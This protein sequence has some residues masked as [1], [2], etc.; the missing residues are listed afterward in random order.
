MSRLFVILNG[1]PGSGK[2]TI[3]RE[4]AAGLGLPLLAKDE[5]KEALADVLMPAT[6]DESRRLG[7]AAVAALLRIARDSQGAVLEGPFNRTIAR[8]E[9]ASLVGDVVEVFCRCPREVA[10]ARYRTRVGTRH[11][12]HHD[13]LRT[14]DEL[15]H[16][17]YSQP[18]AGPWPLI[19][20]DTTTPIDVPDLVRKISSY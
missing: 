1:P 16:D 20:L 19:D 4:L 5:I 10:L 18:I 13:E 15:W 2:T 9:L 14:D 12:C 7:R 17:D 3:A 6:V 11:P 8:G